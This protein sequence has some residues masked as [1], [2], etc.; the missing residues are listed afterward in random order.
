MSVRSAAEFR[1]LNRLRTLD[2]PYVLAEGLSQPGVISPTDAYEL[3]SVEWDRQ[4]S[5]GNVLKSTIKEYRGN[6]A[7]FFTYLSARGIEF[8]YEVD[9][10][11]C[12]D[13]LE[14]GQQENALISSVAMMSK[15]SAMRAF[16]GTCTVLGLYDLNPSASVSLPGKPDPKHP[17]ITTAE[18]ELLKDHAYMTVDD[19]RVPTML[20]LTLLCGGS[21]ALCISQVGDVDFENLRVWF[22]EDGQRVISRW[23]PI[24]PES[25]ELEAL[26][27][28]VAE[29]AE[30][31]GNAPSHPDVQRQLLCFNPKKKSG[32]SVGLESRQ[33]T[34]AKRLTDLM[35]AARIYVEGE[36]SPA[37]I[38]NR[39]A[40]D[41]YEST[42]SIEVVAERLGMRTLDSVAFRVQ[43]DWPTLRA[44]NIPGP[45]LDRY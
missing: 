25:W 29:I 9:V 12:R 6:L 30:R 26:R 20:A 42:G 8:L 2:G 11:L 19:F 40:K 16:F 10:N 21:R 27:I 31:E 36:N 44:I 22:E 1:P 28:R 38:R 43:A 23:V 14:A 5:T 45:G 3:V 34:V 37:A 33:T 41:L 35:I 7:P 17:F 32:K 18:L 15:R 13:F 24:P 4:V 39:V